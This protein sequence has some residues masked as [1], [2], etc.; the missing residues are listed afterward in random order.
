MQIGG[1]LDR[2]NCLWEQWDCRLCTGLPPSSWPCR[3]WSRKKDLQWAWNRDRKAVWD[4]VGL[5]HGRHDI[6][7]M[8][9]DEARLRRGHNDQSRPGHQCS[10]TMLTGES[11]SHIS[12]PWGLNPG[13]LWQEANG[14]TTGPVEL[15]VNAV[16]L[17]ALHKIAKCPRGLHLCLIRPTNLCIQE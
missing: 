2:W 9:Q 1:P 3:L 14:W 16:R 5:S 12:T 17:Q 4:Q 7:V 13:P 11:R 10:E 15:C 6:Q 8:V